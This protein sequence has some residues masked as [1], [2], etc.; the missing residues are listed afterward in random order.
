MWVQSLSWED[1]LEGTATRF[2][3]L[4]GEFHGQ[5]S[6]VGCG[7]QDHKE[8]DTTEVTAGDLACTHAYYSNIQNQVISSTF[9]FLPVILTFLQMKK[10]TFNH[11]V[12]RLLLDWKG[13]GEGHSTITY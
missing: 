3:M 2:S 4:P 7:P 8:S 11:K 12:Q 13:E 10:N 1:P 9:N 5:R 6:V